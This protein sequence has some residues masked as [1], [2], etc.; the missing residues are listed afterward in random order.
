MNPAI[1][2]CTRPGSTEFT[3]M[4]CLPS[5]RAAFLANMSAP[6]LPAA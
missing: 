6:A 4:P 1:G 5:S 2:V 3:R